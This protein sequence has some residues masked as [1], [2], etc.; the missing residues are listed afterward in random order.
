MAKPKDFACMRSVHG[1]LNDDCDNLMGSEYALKFN[2]Y[3]IDYCETTPKSEQ[4]LIQGIIHMA[5]G[6]TPQ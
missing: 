6:T 3:V 2:K 5:C 4:S 1:Y